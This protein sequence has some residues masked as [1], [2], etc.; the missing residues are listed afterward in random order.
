MTLSVSV[1]MS[2][3]G[4]PGNHPTMI[5][6]SA[7]IVAEQQQKITVVPPCHSALR[8]VCDVRLGEPCVLFHAVAFPPS[9][10]QLVTPLAVA[11]SSPLSNS[12]ARMAPQPVLR[13]HR[14]SRAY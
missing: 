9:R 4:F 2:A 3:A 1:R 6:G 7:L 5:P 10:R 11:P 8:A 12:E 14:Q 13:H